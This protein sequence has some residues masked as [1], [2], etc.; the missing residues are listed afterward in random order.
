MAQGGPRWPGR[1][2]PDRLGESRMSCTTIS[3]YT[4]QIVGRNLLCKSLIHLRLYHVPR[5]TTIYRLR[6]HARV[7]TYIAS[8]VFFLV[9]RGTGTGHKP[10]TP[11]PCSRPR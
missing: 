7:H 4:Q 1:E 5:C 11:I 10:M 2:P 6:M 8:S 9:H 3:W